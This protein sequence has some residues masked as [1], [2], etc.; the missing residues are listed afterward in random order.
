MIELAEEEFGL[1]PASCF[2][3][4]DNWSD[5]ELGHRVGATS[6]LVR[7]GYGGQVE[8]QHTVKADY[9]VDDI[10]EAASAI[11]RIIAQGRGIK[12]LANG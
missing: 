5:V 10:V 11:Q 1:Q 9:V 12:G 4:G 3:I 8:A 6:I 2:V 7:T